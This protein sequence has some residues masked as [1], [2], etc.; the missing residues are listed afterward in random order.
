MGKGAWFGYEPAGEHYK[1]GMSSEDIESRVITDTVCMKKVASD[2]VETTE[3]PCDS[4]SVSTERTWNF[5]EGDVN[6]LN[7][8]YS[9]N[10]SGYTAKTQIVSTSLYCC[11]HTNA[12]VFGFTQNENCEAAHVFLAN[13]LGCDRSI[14]TRD[15]DYMNWKYL[16]GPEY[17]YF[18]P[19]ISCS[20]P[21]TTIVI[22][23][24]VSNIEK[25]DCGNVEGPLK[26]SFASQLQISAAKI[27]V[28][29]DGSG[30]CTS[31]RLRRALEI[32]SQKFKIEA[33]VKEKILI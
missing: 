25:A 22:S 8:L 28:A 14:L 27:S 4:I 18:E 17:K 9:W 5:G 7:G 19:Q 26:E 10:G 30:I 11:T 1:I 31:G 3:A 33:T 29:P 2:Y 20:D 12:W 15:P 6:F 16:D 32:G 24:T 23:L 13:P 21:E